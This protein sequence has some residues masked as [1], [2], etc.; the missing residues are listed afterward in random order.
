M[1]GAWCGFVVWGLGV[2]GWTSGGVIASR[3]AEGGCCNCRRHRVAGVRMVRDIAHSLVIVL[4]MTVW[5]GIL[6]N[7]QAQALSSAE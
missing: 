5:I 6:R 4:F 3:R 2:H 7:T 1:I